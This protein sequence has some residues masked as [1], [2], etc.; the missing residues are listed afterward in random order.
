MSA[1]ATMY[2]KSVPK[3]TD[4][5]VFSVKA[6]ECRS[7]YIKTI[8][9]DVANVFKIGKVPKIT[10]APEKWEVRI[11]MKTVEVKGDFLAIGTNREIGDRNDPNFFQLEHKLDDPICVSRVHCVIYFY[12]EFAVVVDLWSFNGTDVVLG[13][14]V[15]TSQKGERYFMKIVKNG[16]VVLRNCDTAPNISIRKK[17]DMCEEKS[18]VVEECVVCMDGPRS[19]VIA[20]CGHKCLCANCASTCPAQ[21]TKCPMC[22]VNI[23]NIMRVFD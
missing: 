6:N 18:D 23:T 12:E 7:I 4:A 2:K 15:M 10:A 14:R 11:G 20:P 1:Y 21:M 9:E 22:R 19:H 17:V 3:L 8:E 13:E 5:N 16:L